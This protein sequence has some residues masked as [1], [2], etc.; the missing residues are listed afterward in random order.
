MKVLLVLGRRDVSEGFEEAVVVEP[1][2]TL[3]GGEFDSAP[4]PPRALPMHDFGLE[5]AD[6]TLRQAVAVGVARV[7]TEGSMR[8]SASGSVQRIER[9]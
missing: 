2:D 1:P 5:E 7:P 8:G 3:K 9:Y 6:H 4:G